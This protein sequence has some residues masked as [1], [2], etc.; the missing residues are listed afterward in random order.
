MH[1][2]EC[3]NETEW[4]AA[5]NFRQ[6]YFFGPSNIV[7]PY[8]WTFNHPSHKHFVLY[9]NDEIVGYVHIQL[10]P[11]NRAAMR[12]I[13]IDE[14]KRNQNLGSEFLHFCEEWLRNHKYKSLHLESRPS[15]FR[16]Y[17]KNG[18]VNMTFNDPNGDDCGLPDIPMGKIF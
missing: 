7:D 14:T 4:N 10:W 11:E 17:Q 5:K 3:N 9:Q 18:Y 8:T 1:M 2:S 13:V 16:F 15:S 6:K 12:I